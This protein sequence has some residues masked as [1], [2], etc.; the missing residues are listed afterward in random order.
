MLKVVATRKQV[1]HNQTKVIFNFLPALER[2][3]SDSQMF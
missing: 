2:N 1:Y 3:W